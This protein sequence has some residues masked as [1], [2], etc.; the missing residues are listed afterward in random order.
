MTSTTQAEKVLLIES[1]H[2]RYQIV[3]KP[4]FGVYILWNDLFHS[5][6][7]CPNIGPLTDWQAN[8]RSSPS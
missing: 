8:W 4:S 1:V 6:Q 5:T 2:A 3:D 7:R